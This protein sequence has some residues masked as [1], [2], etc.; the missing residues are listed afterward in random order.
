MDISSLSLAVFRAASKTRSTNSLT[1]FSARPVYYGKNIYDTDVV[2][3]KLDSQGKYL[4][5]E[6]FITGWLSNGK[7]SGRPVDLK[8]HAGSLFISDDYSGVIYKVS[9]VSQ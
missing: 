2:R 6:D 7:V 3:Y 8:F 9:R 5:E 1:V 4:S